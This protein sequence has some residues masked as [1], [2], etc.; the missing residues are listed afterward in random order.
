MNP[1]FTKYQNKGYTG[2]VN[3]GNT[4]FLNSCIQVLNHTYEL[5]ELM[6]SNKIQSHLKRDVDDSVIVNEWIELHNVMWSDNGTVSPNKFVHFVH[7]LAHHKKK[8]IFTGWAQNDLPEFIFFII[9]CMHNSIS[10]PIHM[11][12][13]GEP[14]NK[15][16]KLAIECYSVLKKIYD[17]EYSEIMELFYGIYISQ[18]SSSDGTVIHTIKPEHYFILDLDIPENTPNCSIYDCLDNM[19][20]VEV[21][22][23]DN[24]WYNESTACKENIQKKIIFWNFPNILIISFKRFSFDGSRKLNNQIDFPHDLDLSKY[25]NGYN[26]STFKYKLFGVCNHIGNIM[27]GH[28]TSFVKN[29]TNEWIHYNDTSV[30]MIKDNIQCII[31]PMAYCLFYRKKNNGL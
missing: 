28:Y 17:K 4:C 19:I 9:E 25:I 29:A 6:N 27:G 22:E 5:V 13:R 30:E 10:R 2:L 1:A 31:S 12:I 7:R 20:K 14:V 23:G 26:A 24:A 15:V 11:K 3:L 21:L 16:D 8:E 18:I